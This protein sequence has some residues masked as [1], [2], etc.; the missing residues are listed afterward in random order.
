MGRALPKFAV[1][2]F[3]RKI[4][5]RLSSRE[6]KQ[7]VE[8]Q[9]LQTGRLGSSAKQQLNWEQRF[10]PP[11]A[12]ARVYS[13]R[14]RRVVDITTELVQPVVDALRAQ[15]APDGLFTLTRRNYVEGVSEGGG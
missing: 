1:G 13:P 15:N 7:T 3:F 6:L 8:V 12:G 5:S 2:L 11:H 9:G 14:L 4:E 10:Q